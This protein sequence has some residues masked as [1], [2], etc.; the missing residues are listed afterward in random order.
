MLKGKGFFIWKIKDCEGGNASA[1]ASVAKTAGFSHVLIKIADGAYPNNVDPSTQADYCPPVVAALHSKG[2]QVWGWHYVYGNA[3][4][5]AKMAI[6]RIKELGLDGYAIDAEVEYQE[7]GRDV[8]AKR[9]MTELR[10]SL[11]HLPI[12]ICS[13][14]FPSLHGPFPWQAFLDKCDYNMPQVYWEGAHNAGAQLQRCVREFK[15][16]APYRPIIP[17]G[18]VYRWNNWG[19]TPQEMKEFLDTARTLNLPG[20]NFFT[21]DYRIKL[22]PLWDVIAPYPWSGTPFQDISEQ[23]ITALNSHDANLV[24]A[25]YSTDAVHITASSTIQGIVAIRAWFSNYFSK[26]LPNAVF[27]L[28]GFTGDTTKRH[29]TWEASSPSGKV[30]NGKDTFGLIG[31]AITYHY[32]SF[33]VSPA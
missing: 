28:T 6:H 4:P 30:L 13:F 2:I 25:L 3:I 1:I 32:T 10:N 31:G 26:T 15:A 33:T 17:V 7:P 19:A 5:E 21:W 11:P 8:D 23:Y 14:R 9:F 20:I 29:F 24:G 16:M 27:K 22:K 18:P 12:A